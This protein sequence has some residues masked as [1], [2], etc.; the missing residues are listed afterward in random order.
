MRLNSSII[1]KQENTHYLYYK[2]YVSVT[3]PPNEPI[4]NMSSIDFHQLPATGF[5]MTS[6]FPRH[7]ICKQEEFNFFL[8][9]DINREFINFPCGISME[10]SLSEN[11]GFRIF[12]WIYLGLLKNLMVFKGR[13][14]LKE[15]SLPNQVQ[16]IF[17]HLLKLVLFQFIDSNY[18]L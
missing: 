4:K 5:K 18:G 13:T 12:H 7:N 17:I 1:K 15:L 11:V 16:F 6:T 2:E 9:Q 10:A 3:I 8:N 14:D